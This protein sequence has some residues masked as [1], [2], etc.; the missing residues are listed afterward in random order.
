[1]KYKNKV[2]RCPN[3]HTFYFLNLIYLVRVQKEVF[4]ASLGI[5]QKRRL[6]FQERRRLVPFLEHP[7]CTDIDI[8]DK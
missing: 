8:A 2:N 4:G 1:M 5:L 3:S 7:L 6:S